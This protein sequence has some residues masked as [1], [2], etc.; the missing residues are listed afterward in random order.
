MEPDRLIDR[1]I[2]IMEL[3]PRGLIATIVYHA[4]LLLL[5][6]FAGLTFPDPPPEEEGILVNFGTDEFGLGDFEPM[7]DDQQAG[8]PD[9]EVAQ[10]Q[11]PVEETEEYAEPVETRES[12]PP[13]EPVEVDQTQ[14]VEEVQVKEQPSPEELERQVLAA[15]HKTK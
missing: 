6:I 3:K 8:D 5:L 10:Y 12:A 2:N 11:E 1:Y 4:L 14:D 15:E 7:G 9:Q 13:P